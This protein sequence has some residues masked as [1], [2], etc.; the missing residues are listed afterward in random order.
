MSLGLNTALLA[1][2]LISGRKIYFL[3]LVYYR[4]YP[5]LTAPSATHS[6]L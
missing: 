5:Q 6:N 1:K 4:I 2:A 3:K